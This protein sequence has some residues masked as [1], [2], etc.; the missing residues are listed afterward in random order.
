MQYTEFIHPEDA[1]ALKAL[2]AIPMLSTIIKKVMDVGIEQLQTGLN[3]ASK[4][5]LTPTQLP[6]LYNILPPI[7]ER[8]EIKEPEFYLEMN[9]MPQCLCFWRHADGN[10][11]H[12][13]IGGHDV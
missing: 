8:L 13:G 11:Y 1:A 6:R 5:K 12:L 2:K 3:M 9:P 4:V 7:C 10:H